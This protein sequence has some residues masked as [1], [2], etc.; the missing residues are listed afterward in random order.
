MNLHEEVLVLSIPIIACLMIYFATH[1]NRTLL[2]YASKKALKNAKHIEE[3]EE[4]DLNDVKLCLEYIENKLVYQWYGHYEYPTFDERVQPLAENLTLA[5][6]LNLWLSK[7]ISINAD[8]S[9]I[10]VH[11]NI[12][13][14]HIALMKVQPSKLK[15]NELKE[16][17][18]EL[19]SIVNELKALRSY[20]R[21]NNYLLTA[22]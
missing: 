4:T 6:N 2:A 14:E 21:T 10:F 22:I 8:V 20:Q 3:N 18:E 9:K 15:Q 19:T 13:V 11:A 12:L 16:I 5:K 7:R 17:N 1:T